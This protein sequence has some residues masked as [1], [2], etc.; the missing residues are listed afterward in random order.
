MFKEFEEL[1]ECEKEGD[2]LKSTAKA[3]VDYNNL[4]DDGK[5][6]LWL[7]LHLMGKHLKTAL[8]K[9][10]FNID[11]QTFE[12]VTLVREGRATSYLGSLGPDMQVVEALRF[13]SAEP[14]RAD[15]LGHPQPR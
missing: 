14:Q 11:S 3:R 4:T 9:T 13:F 2:P 8:D 5:R 1:R 7:G 6:E 10:D 15:T 12:T